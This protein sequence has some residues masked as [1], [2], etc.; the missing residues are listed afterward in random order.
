M[1]WNFICKVGCYKRDNWRCLLCEN[2]EEV[3]S[4]SS[5]ITGESF[6]INHHLGCNDKYNI[7]VRQLTDR[8]GGTTIKKVKGNIGRTN[9][10]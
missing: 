6:T 2:F 5:T 9:T 10:L 8:P 4:F 3:D 7:Q 1:Q